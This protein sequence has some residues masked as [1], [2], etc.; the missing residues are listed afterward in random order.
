MSTSEILK[1]LKSLRNCDPCSHLPLLESEQIWKMKGAL[2][3][4]AATLIG[5]SVA[6]LRQW[7]M[8]VPEFHEALQVMETYRVAS[9]MESLEDGLISSKVAVRVIYANGREVIEPPK[10][11]RN[12]G[13]EISLQ[14]FDMARIN[15]IDI[16][17]L[18]ES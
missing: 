16:L 12:T 3:W 13:S 15:A 14:G 11:V 10:V 18:P 6:K 8:D 17:E 9:V 7:R 4:N 5:T 1:K 2:E